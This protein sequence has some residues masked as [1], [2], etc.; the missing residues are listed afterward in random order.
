MVQCD[1]LLRDHF[2]QNLQGTRL[3]AYGKSTSR[4]DGDADAWLCS[5]FGVI[6]QQPAAF[7][8]MGDGLDAA[9]GYWLYADPVHLALMRDFFVLQG[10]PHDLLPQ[11]TQQMVATLNKHFSADGMQWYAPHP[12]R[13]YLRLDRPLEITAV[14]KKT[15][16]GTKI[17]KD[18]NS[19][20]Y[21]AMLNEI[22]MLL[23]QHAVNS[24]REEAELLPVNSVWLWGGGIYE[25]PSLQPYAA[26]MAD[27]PLARGLAGEHCRSVPDSAEY[28]P[29]QDT[30]LVVLEEMDALQFEQ[31]WAAPLLSMLKNNKVQKLV[32]HLEQEQHV[33]SFELRRQDLW[34]IWRKWLN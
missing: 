1:I 4:F 10:T 32:L 9:Q 30:G 26:V 21:A 28:L 7:S 23:H 22:Q 27:D 6:S 34:K 11:Q 15:A 8:A 29:Q 2:A 25:S 33:T 24:E 13:W 20:P 16:T 3:L 19:A 31:K 18:M 12:E 5:I 17:S 14:S